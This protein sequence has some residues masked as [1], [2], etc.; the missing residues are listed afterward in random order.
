MWESK[1]NDQCNVTEQQQMDWHTCC[2][3]S[4][5]KI[6]LVFS[7]EEKTRVLRANFS[8]Y[9]LEFCGLKEVLVKSLVWPKSSW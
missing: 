9:I 1:S 6:R 8:F 4:K 2:C 5:N 7:S 3:H